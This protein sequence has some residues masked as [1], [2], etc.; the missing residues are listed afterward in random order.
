[1]LVPVQPQPAVIEL[2]VEKLTSS[3]AADTSPANSAAE[4]S[5]INA[6][7]ITGGHALAIVLSIT[8]ILS[9]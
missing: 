8:R 7:A 5:K 6:A 3:S 9:F 2:C 1:M 4:V